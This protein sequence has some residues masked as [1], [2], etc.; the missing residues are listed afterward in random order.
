MTRWFRKAEAQTVAPVQVEQFTI[1]VDLDMPHLAKPGRPIG[2]RR[3]RSDQRRGSSSE[4]GYGGPWPKA[5]E[6]FRREFP[7]CGMR[8]GGRA[9]VMSKCAEQ[10]L[11]TTV[12][13]QDEHGRAN[14]QTD[15]V[16]PHRGN[17]ALFWDRENNWQSLCRSCGA[18]KSR[19]GL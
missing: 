2:E 12:I 4:R 13:G 6:A 11:L 7:L 8:P 10:G 18:R 14:G 9:P 5:S 1:E 15:H 19:A 17:V 16:I 3:K